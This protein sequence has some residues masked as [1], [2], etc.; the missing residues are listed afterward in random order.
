MSTTLPLEPFSPA[1]LIRRVKRRRPIGEVAA[2]FGLDPPA[3]GRALANLRRDD[4]AFPVRRRRLRYVVYV[5]PAG[6]LGEPS[7]RCVGPCGRR[8]PVS[9]FSRYG[10][11]AIST[12]CRECCAVGAAA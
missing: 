8:L 5:E 2:L 12:T 1:A 7:M 10:P 11:A 6:P 9:A 3:L 4:P